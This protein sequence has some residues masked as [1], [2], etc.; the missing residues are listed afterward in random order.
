MNKTCPHF[1]PKKPLSLHRSFQKNGRTLKIIL[2]NGSFKRRSDSKR[3]ERFYC[4]LCHLYF[5]R[6][7]FSPAYLQKKRRLN[8]LLYKLYSSG[9]SQRRAALILSINPKTAVRKF[10]FIAA[11]SD[12]KHHQWQKTLKTH[13]LNLIQFDDLETSEHTKCKPLSVCLAVEPKTRKILSFKVSRMPAK[14]HLAKIARARYGYRKDERDRGW[15]EMM[16]ELKDIVQPNTHF[17]SDENPHYKRH[18]KRAFPLSSHEQ[19][20]G[21]RAAVVGQGE[22]KKGGFDPLFSLNHTCAMLRANLNR[23]FRRTWCTTKT[24][25]GL[26][27]HL[28]IY[29]AYHNQ[30]L[31]KEI[32]SAE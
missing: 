16:K 1:H 26:R 24:I 21:R 2:R 10:H 18:V 28:Y 30:V 5:S 29:V 25:Q 12:D 7:S 22:L 15:R 32:G 17:I 23:L 11:R 8:P 27:D 9:V 14:G 13:P 31:T 20:R 19:H 4:R 3:I 6:A